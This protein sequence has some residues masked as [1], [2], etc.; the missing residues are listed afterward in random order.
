MGYK[1]S[2]DIQA[3]REGKALRK[4]GIRENTR[5]LRLETEYKQVIEQ[6]AFR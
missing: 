3:E 5:R 4:Q 2:I 1:N 6:K